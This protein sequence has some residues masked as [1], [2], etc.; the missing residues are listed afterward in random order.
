MLWVLSLARRL[1]SF[2]YVWYRGHSET[3]TNKSMEA[4]TECG[5]IR[6]SFIIKNVLN[7]GSK[8]ASREMRSCEMKMQ[9]LTTNAKFGI[10]VEAV[11]I[12]SNDSNGVDVWLLLIL[13]L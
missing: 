8:D 6:M 9:G 10:S 1:D 12:C 3:Y 7:R 11:I 2:L 5:L 13:M 4:L